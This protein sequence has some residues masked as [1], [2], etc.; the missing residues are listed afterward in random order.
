MPMIGI[1][2]I[3]WKKNAAKMKFPITMGGVTLRDRIT[4]TSQVTSVIRKLNLIG[5]SEEIW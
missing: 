3:R 5:K 2:K 4:Y 1:K